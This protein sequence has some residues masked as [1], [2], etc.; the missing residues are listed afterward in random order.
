MQ[1]EKEMRENTK[2]SKHSMGNKKVKE[3]NNIMSKKKK[4]RKMGFSHGNWLMWHHKRESEE[5]DTW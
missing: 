2:V 4:M 3:R 1:K 5:G